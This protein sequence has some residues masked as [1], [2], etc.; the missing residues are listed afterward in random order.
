VWWPSRL[1]R[2]WKA[3][4]VQICRRNASGFVAKSTSRITM[5]A[6]KAAL[7]VMYCILKIRTSEAYQHVVQGGLLRSPPVGLF[8]LMAWLC[9]SPVQARQFACLLS[10]RSERLACEIQ[11][12]IDHRSSS[13]HCCG[14]TSG[15]SSRRTKRQFYLCVGVSLRVHRRFPFTLLSL[16]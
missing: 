5:W 2:I 14:T 9:P 3:V 13:M 8:D 15:Q 7:D 1:Y 6:C 4:V 11:P 12:V 10:V 16:C